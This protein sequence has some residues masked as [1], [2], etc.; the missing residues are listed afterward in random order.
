MMLI[1]GFAFSLVGYFWLYQQI[2]STYFD[3][4]HQKNDS[5]QYPAGYNM[6]GTWDY[7]VL[8]QTWPPGYCQFI[9]CSSPRVINGF[10]IHGL[11]AQ[12]WPNSEMNG[13]GDS[14]KYDN[15]SIK[16]IFE[17]LK[18]E[19]VDEK[20][21]NHPWRFWR[22]EWEKHG[23]CVIQNNSVI[24]NQREYF[25]ASLTLKRMYN[26]TKIFDRN[27]IVA[28]NTTLYDTLSVL[29]ILRRD[30]GADVRL[31]CSWKNGEYAKLV[32]VRICLNKSF[33]LLNCPP[34]TSGFGLLPTTPSLVWTTTCPKA[35]VVSL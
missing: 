29:N 34:T 35:F 33:K 13:C 28:S 7:L 1:W 18:R 16:D 15:G 14:P 10:N 24:T 5:L 19:W 23:I 3:A 31:Q 9:A 26:F 2:I 4:R 20:S 32:E 21:F 11:W 25:G 27:Y 30:L 22:H 6:N 17:E 8:T 12:L